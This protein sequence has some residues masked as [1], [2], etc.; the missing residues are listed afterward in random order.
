MVKIVGVGGMVFCLGN[1][2]CMLSF[3]PFLQSILWCF[4]YISCHLV[5]KTESNICLQVWWG[6]KYHSEGVRSNANLEKLRI[7]YNGKC[8][9]R[10]FHTGQ[11]KLFCWQIEMRLLCLQ[12]CFLCPPHT[13]LL[14]FPPHIIIPLV[15]C[16]R[17]LFRCLYHFP[18]THNFLQ[19]LY[20]LPH[21]CKGMA[22]R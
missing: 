18:S 4:L 19:G 11:L 12:I 10:L 6:K 3:V 13:R 9:D 20:I 21:S 16:R 1:Y 15:F 22:F 14:F 17:F 8:N 2:T 5:G 7:L